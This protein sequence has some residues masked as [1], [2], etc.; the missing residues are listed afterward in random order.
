MLLQLI[1]ILLYFI[2]SKYGVSSLIIISYYYFLL[3]FAFSPF[4]LF[5]IDVIM[6]GRFIKWFLIIKKRR[7][8]FF[9]C[10]LV[11]RNNPQKGY[12]VIVIKLD[13]VGRYVN[14]YRLLIYLI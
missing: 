6:D 14:K 12:D 3:L 2:Q 11:P 9:I 5:W 13:L 10:T 8:Y 4:L 1:I 7:N